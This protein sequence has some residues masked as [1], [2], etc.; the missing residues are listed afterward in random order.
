MTLIRSAESIDKNVFA[1]SISSLGIGNLCFE[2]VDRVEH[3]SLMFFTEQVV[4]L[5]ADQPMR[6]ASVNIENICYSPILK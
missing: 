4:T 6:R 3:D 2:A 1:Y 5:L